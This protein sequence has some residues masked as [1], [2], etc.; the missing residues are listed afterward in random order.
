MDETASLVTEVDTGTRKA[1]RTIPVP[2]RP[3]GAALNKSADRLYVT[4]DSPANSIFVIDLITGKVEFTL[5]SGAGPTAPVLSA[6][7]SLLY[8]SNRFDNNVSVIDL[9]EKRA[10]KQIPVVREPVTAALSPD[11]KLLVI[12]N[13]KPAGSATAPD[14]ASVVSLVDAQTNSVSA[15]VRLPDGGGSIRGVAI[16]PDS[17]Y[18]FVSHLL[19][20]PHAPATQLEQGWLNAN[21][22]SVIDLE[23]KR[24]LN[25]MMLDQMGQGAGNPWGIAVSPDGNQLY[26]VLA[27]VHQLA[28]INLPPLLEKLRK[29]EVEPQEIPRMDTHP[30]L[31]KYPKL[32]SGNAYQP[33][34]RPDT[35]LTFLESFMKRIPLKGRGP[36]SLVIRGRHAYLGMYFSGTLETLDLSNPK[37]ESTVIS[38]G[39]QPAETEARRGERLFHDAK[40]SFQGWQSCSTCH[41]DGR[42]DGFNWDLTNDGVGTTKNTKSF[43]FAWATPPVTWTGILPSI[44]E[45]VPHELKTILFAS[46]PKEDAAAIV[47]YIKSLQ[48]IP[49]PYLEKGNKL[50]AAA[51]RG[52]L[53][54]T[55]AGCIDC[56][57]G[58]YMT[59]MQMRNVGTSTLA[60]RTSAFD[61][62][63][64]REVWRTAPYLHDG[65]AA[66]LK[67]IF[68][69]FD[70]RKI[71]GKSANLSPQELD[72]LVQYVLTL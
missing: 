14:F 23:K 21:A 53:A 19:G 3:T 60:D 51:Q 33:H 65:R 45:C 57:K 42:S 7:E 26:V 12:G 20:R 43:L 67:D 58:H 59:S 46:P 15:T 40:L 71:H 17:R 69:K 61:I 5:E 52:Q 16:S 6:D 66:S 50:S 68:L 8:V 29:L 54:F 25:T 41:I 1:I 31:E 4:G 32:T 24:R 55:K 22:F 63:T 64:L 18:A 70:P 39:P 48:P 30:G 49:S 27:G 9:N 38:M 34:G 2:G 47:A 10:V 62:P 36:R 35:D 56:H 37:T 28:A 13:Q 72:D 11:G 44:I